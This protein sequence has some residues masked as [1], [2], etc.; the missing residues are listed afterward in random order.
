MDMINNRFGILLANKRMIEKRR[1]SLSEVSKVTGISRQSLQSWE[2][3]T[4]TRFDLPI[5]DALCVY[6]DVQ[7][8]ALFQYV[9]HDRKITIKG[10]EDNPAELL[11]KHNAPH[12]LD[13]HLD[14]EDMIHA[15]ETKIKHRADP[16]PFTTFKKN[17]KKKKK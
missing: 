12:F 13:A 3:N 9:E 10:K 15:Q 4:V 6:F 1:I 16:T 2:N 5:M 7:P 14:I 17:I 11:V 8:G